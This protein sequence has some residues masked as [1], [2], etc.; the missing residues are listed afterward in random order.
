MAVGVILYLWS[1]PIIVCMQWK[2]KYH[3]KFEHMQWKLT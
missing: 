2:Q 3:P 1:H